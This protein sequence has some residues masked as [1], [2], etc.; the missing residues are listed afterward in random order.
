[1]FPPKGE[2]SKELIESGISYKLSRG[3]TI[4]LL[5]YYLDFITINNERVG[6]VTSSTSGIDNI[7]FIKNKEL[8]DIVYFWMGQV[9]GWIDYSDEEKEIPDGETKRWDLIV[10][11]INNKY[12]L[13]VWYFELDS[14]YYDHYDGKEYDNSY[15]LKKEVIIEPGNLNQILSVF[16]KTTT[17]L[18]ESNN[19]L[20]N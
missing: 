8:Y 3:N 12:T 15:V 13:Q 19:I 6:W 2:L 7:K 10:K 11:S 17:R 14:Y 4:Q 5:R 18:V 1:M 16:A 9:E 20:I